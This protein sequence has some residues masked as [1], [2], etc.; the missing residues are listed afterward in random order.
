LCTQYNHYSLSIINYSLIKRFLILLIRLYQVM[1]SPYLGNNCRHAPS[2][3]HYAIE[4]IREWG[5][6]KGL[7]LG[8]RRISRC[9]PWGT[10]GYDP[11]PKKHDH[12]QKL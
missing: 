6:I 4:A 11:V 9:H 10:A 12:Q 2:C 5:P 8:L 3:S 7:W 1:L